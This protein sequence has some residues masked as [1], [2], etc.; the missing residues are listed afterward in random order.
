MSYDLDLIAKLYAMAMMCVTVH[1]R[2]DASVNLKRTCLLNNIST[3]LSNQFF[4]LFYL[5]FEK[6]K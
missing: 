5:F 3:M 2:F 6:K 1:E 4:Y